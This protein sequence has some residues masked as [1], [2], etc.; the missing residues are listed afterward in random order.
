MAKKKVESATEVVVEEKAVVTPLRW[1]GVQKLLKR[2]V[3]YAGKVDGFAGRLTISS[4]QLLLKHRGFYAGDV[5]GLQNKEMIRSLQS[6]L[7]SEYSAGLEISGVM[8]E[9]TENALKIVNSELDK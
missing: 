4:L 6:W 7:N 5:T 1:E 9:S 8:D 3:G 2:T